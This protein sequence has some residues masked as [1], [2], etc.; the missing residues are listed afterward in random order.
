MWGNL[1]TANDRVTWF[2]RL[3]NS[4][5]QPVEPT[6]LK[7]FRAA[8]AVRPL[9]RREVWNPIGPELSAL[10]PRGRIRNVTPDGERIVFE[11]PS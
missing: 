8:P 5:V 1:G 4:S 9:H 7:D 6:A 11:V 10:Y 2:T 3:A